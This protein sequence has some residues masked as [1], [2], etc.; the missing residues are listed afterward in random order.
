MFRI[1]KALFFALF[2]CGVYYS[3]GWFVFILTV[4]NPG[5]TIGGLFLILFT[6]GLLIFGDRRF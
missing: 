6:L 3:L 2:C 5:A 1:L 4:K